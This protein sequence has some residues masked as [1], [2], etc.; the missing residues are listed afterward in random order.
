M[1][2]ELMASASGINLTCLQAH[3]C[4]VAQI[5]C[6]SVLKMCR[7]SSYKFS[8]IVERRAKT[9]L[10]LSSI[11][12]T[13]VRCA[14]SVHFCWR[15]PWVRQSQCTVSRLRNA[16]VCCLAVIPRG[17]SSPAAKLQKCSL[18][19]KSMILSQLTLNIVEV[20]FGYGAKHGCLTGDKSGFIL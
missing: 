12:W 4:L 19:D 10:L 8:S 15:G 6:L 13:T 2:S 9:S 5:L 14:F 7:A 1:H 20:I 3:P 16:A 11:D 17:T 18:C